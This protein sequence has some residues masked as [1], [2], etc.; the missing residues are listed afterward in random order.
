MGKAELKKMTK[1]VPDLLKFPSD[2]SFIDYDKEADVLYISFEK[3]QQATDSELMENDVIMRTRQ[4][5]LVGMT[6]LNASKRK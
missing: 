1:V 2:H 4:G 5:R 6:F 3:P